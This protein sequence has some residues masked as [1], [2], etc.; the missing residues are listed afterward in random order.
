MGEAKRRKQILG[1]SY[2]QAV[3]VEEC[4]I[5]SEIHFG[6]ADD[7]Q[8]AKKSTDLAYM[9]DDFKYVFFT[10]ILK[11]QSMSEP[12]IVYGEALKFSGNSGVEVS[13]RSDLETFVHSRCPRQKANGLVTR[14]KK[15]D[16]S[17]HRTIALL[18]GS[19]KPKL[20]VN[21]YTLHQLDILLKNLKEHMIME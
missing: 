15:V 19:T 16:Y 10:C 14:L 17:T 5:P 13:F 11:A 21:V 3:P 9:S 7:N 6:F 2:G 20:A 12:G 8:I 1:S 18:A 4:I